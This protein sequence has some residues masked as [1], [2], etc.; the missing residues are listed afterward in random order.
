MK[1]VNCNCV[2]KVPL[3]HLS[4]HKQQ[5]VCHNFQGIDDD[6]NVDGALLQATKDADN[7]HGLEVS[8][9]DEL[10]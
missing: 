9:G 1:N 10:S 3:W 7:G 6:E 8:I 2:F 4:S 5:I